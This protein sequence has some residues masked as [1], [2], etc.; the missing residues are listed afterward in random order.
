MRR[1]L[2]MIPMLSVLIVTATAALAQEQQNPLDP[3]F[4]FFGDPA[5]EEF[6]ARFTRDPVEGKG[7]VTDPTGDFEHSTGQE[8]GFTPDHLDMT[9]AWAVEI[10][11]GDIDFFAP[12]EESQFWAPTGPHE[13]DPPNSPTIT[14]FSGDQP[15]DGAQY[16]ESSYLFGFFLADTPPVAVSGRCEFVVWVNDASRGPTFS[17]LPEFPGDPAAG[18]NVAFG[19]G[20]N[21]EGQGMP[22]TFT[23]ELQEGGGFQSNPDLDVRSFITPNYVGITVPK[24]Q[25]G[26][27]AGINW[28]TFCVEDGFSFAPEETG[29]DQTGLIELTPSDLGV[30][31]VEEAV[32]TTTTTLGTTTTSAAGTT[33]EAATATTA[34]G[35]GEPTPIEDGGFP[36]WLMVLGGLGLAI[37]GWYLF[38]KRDPCEELLQAWRRA[39]KA[40]E[41]ARIVADEA[42]EGCMDAELDLEDLVEERKDLCRAWPPACWTTED[43][44]WIEDGQGNRISSRDLHMRRMALGEVW[45]DYRAGKTTAQEVEAK[46]KEMDTPEFHEEMRQ[47][48]EA[49]SE[50]L[51]EIDAD[52]AEAETAAEEACE[53]ADQAQKKADEA[54]AAASAAE[55]AYLECIGAAIA[56]AGA[57]AAGA[58]GEEP[59]SEPGGPTLAA[60]GQT[61]DQADP[62][63][64]VDPK[65]KYV[66]AGNPDRIRVAVD[67]T[68]VVG[69]SS[70]SE[71]NVAAGEQLVFDLNDLARDLDFAGD[72]LGARSAGLHVS[73]AINGYSQGKY[74]ATGAGIIRGGV[75]AAQALSDRVP[76]VPTTPA[77]A[78]TELLEQTARLG[79]F[80]AGKVTEWMG[81]YQIMTARLTT[82]YQSVTATPY[83]RMECREGQGWIC[84]EKVWEIEIGKLTRV[85]G[86][87]K[88]FTVNSAVRRRAFQAAIRTMSQRGADTIRK[89]A[90]LL[91]EWRAM[92]EAGPCS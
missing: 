71:R 40:C 6:V 37:I 24:S 26:M 75:D 36:W 89:D 46:W 13:V 41:E 2:A 67:F 22:S 58:G 14:T 56:Q 48:D 55:K 81:N 92:H 16:N 31:V 28:Y 43:G 53:R 21:P 1:R 80:V 17:N 60:P 69:V 3:I 50:M 25:I 4:D 88:F 49:F 20:I 11:F 59:P 38:A 35:A 30:L 10:D 52:I 19:L 9:S 64:D 51:E 23:L 86:R 74:L 87:D 47:T 76:D 34:A 70:G 32:A 57:T 91:T 5:N 54:C 82:F 7:H 73:G 61:Q 65:V 77:Q 8:P 39:Q 15:H 33:T 18:T 90:K 62:C 44:G 66:K 42:I 68:V 83:E 27:L 72:L 78:G 12:T 63:K 85:Q 84:V 79:A 45:S 29:A